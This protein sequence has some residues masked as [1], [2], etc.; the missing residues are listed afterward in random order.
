MRL[1]PIF[2]ILALNVNSSFTIFAIP[3]HYILVYSAIY[4]N[5]YMRL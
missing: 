5:L 4:S 3:L 1:S 2:E